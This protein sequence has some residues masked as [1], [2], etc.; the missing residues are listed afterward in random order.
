MLSS[1]SHEFRTPINAFSNSMLLIEANYKNLIK[2]LN[3]K[4]NS[5]IGSDILPRQISE[6][7]DKYFKIWKISTT[8]LMWLVE[9]ILDLAKIEAGTFRLVNEPFCVE[10]LVNEIGYIFDFQCA[11]KGLLFRIDAS[12][13]LLRSYFCSDIGRI[14]QVLINLISN[15]FKFTMQGGITLQIIESSKFLPESFERQRGLKFKVI[16]TGVGIDEK[17]ISKLFK[18]FGTANQHRNMNSRGTGLGLSISQKIVKSLGGNIKLK[19]RLGEGTEVTFTT[20]FKIK[21]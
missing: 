21:N 3:E 11:Q 10:T 16:D 7:N 1:V 18:L 20:F 13:E 8:S 9:D 15:A 12:N 4:V 2:N 14:K 5:K 19:S 6:A 17:E